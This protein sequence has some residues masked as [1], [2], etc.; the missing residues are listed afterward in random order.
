MKHRTKMFQSFSS[1]F[2]HDHRLYGNLKCQKQTWFCS[3]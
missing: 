3:N 1:F 2:L